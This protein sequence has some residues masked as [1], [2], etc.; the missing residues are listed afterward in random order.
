MKNMTKICIFIALCLHIVL[1]HSSAYA[2]NFVEIYRDDRYLIS[3][4]AS[5]LKDHGDY[6]TAWEKKIYIGRKL[7]EVKKKYGEKT[8]YN[9]E[10]WA[11]KTNAKEGQLLSWCVYGNDGVV[12]GSN[13][14]TFSPYGFMPLPPESI[15]EILWESVMA[16]TNH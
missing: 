11:Y 5:S 7:E 4:D 12:L 15:G 8:D 10:L 2:A 9:M 1:Q 6:V 13:N 3:I 14:S 16:L